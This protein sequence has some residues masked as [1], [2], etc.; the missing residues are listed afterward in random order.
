MA[1]YVLSCCTT[2]DLD[3]EQYKKLDL[4]VMPFNY[5]INGIQCQEHPD[6]FD[7]EAF[8]AKMK[9]GAETATSASTVEE[10]IDYFK[11]FIEKG[12]GVIHVAL[13]SG[14]SD[15]F[16]R[17]SG[18]MIILRAVYPDCRIR[19]IDSLCASGGIGL[20]MDKAAQLRDEGMEMEELADW[21]ENSRLKVNHLFFSS[22]LSHFIRSGKIS[23]NAG[24]F[25]E[26][27]EICPLMEVNSWGELVPKKNVRTKDKVF[28][29]TME[30]MKRLADNR[31]AYREKIFITHSACPEDAQKL[32]KMVEEAFPEAGE[33]RISGIGATIG[34]HTGVGTVAVFFWGKERTV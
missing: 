26:R 34:S 3:A 10:Y 32:E 31:S 30:T 2:A 24:N 15:A 28:R 6:T 33:I 21:I 23:K 20:L 27:L 12:L 4:K 9:E 11:A 19:V 29:V 8:Y 1:D 16:T 5:S 14:I 13:S 7:P 18:A 22:D 25:A 17:A